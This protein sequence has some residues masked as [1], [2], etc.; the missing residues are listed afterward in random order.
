MVSFLQMH[1][2]HTIFA[3]CYVCYDAPLDDDVDVDDDED[4]DDLGDDDGIMMP[5]PSPSCN[6]HIDRKYYCS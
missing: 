4:D 6:V 5:S 3:S 2:T 1:H